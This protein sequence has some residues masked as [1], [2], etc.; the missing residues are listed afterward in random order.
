MKFLLAAV[1]VAFVVFNPAFAEKRQEKKIDK[2]N[3]EQQKDVK[4]AKKKTKTPGDVPPQWMILREISAKERER[5]RQ[6]YLTDPKTFKQELTKIV[7]RIKQE[8]RKPNI[9]VQQLA[10][11]YKNTDDPKKKKAILAQLR[12]ITRKIFYGKM[13]FNKKRLESLEKQVKTL[14]QQYEFRQKNADKIIQARLDYLTSETEF[15][16]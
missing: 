10:R 2:K 11:Q 5:L 16:W 12:Q 1:L 3:D 14:R 13:E 15:E 4:K 6:L 7:D 9:R 8:K